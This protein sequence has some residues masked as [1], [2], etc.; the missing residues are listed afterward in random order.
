MRDSGATISRMEL[1]LKLG[2]MD[3]YIKAIFKMDRGMVKGSCKMLMA[4]MRAVGRRG[5][6]MAKEPINGR[7]EGNIMENGLMEK[8]MAAVNTVGQM[9]EN[10]REAIKLISNKVMEFILGLMEDRIVDN[11]IKENSMEKGYTRI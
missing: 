5:R 7:M 6:C 8:C 10:M 3:R 9:E 4:N 11:G 2:L 1:E